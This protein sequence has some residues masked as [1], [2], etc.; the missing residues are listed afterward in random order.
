M[1]PP[2]RLP[3]PSAAFIARYL[4]DS[5][6]ILQSLRHSALGGE[7][8]SRVHPEIRDLRCHAHQHFQGHHHGEDYSEA[9]RRGQEGFF[10]DRK[11]TARAVRDHGRIKGGALACEREVH[12]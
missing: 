10:R 5:W 11:D 12:S 4:A 1:F 8:H 2:L 7:A 9:G 3:G 6:L